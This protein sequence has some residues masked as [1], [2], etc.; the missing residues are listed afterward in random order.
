MYTRVI[1]LHVL[2]VLGF[3]LSHGSASAVMFRLRTEREPARVGALLDLCGA[4]N[5]LTS[6]TTVLLLVA[7]VLGGFMGQWW[8]RGWI[9]TALALF[10]VI[11][12]VMSFLGRIYFERVRRALAPAAND[13]P[14]ATPAEPLAA[15]L[16]S[17]RPVLVTGVG[18]G[19]LAL[20]TWLMMF[21]P[22]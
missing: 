10:V 7:G 2:S 11:G 22:F 19:G 16:D 9:W 4:V 3:L 14:P 21:K 20:I 12:V 6:V 17:G 1:F 8:G 18:L 5:G 13:G 15:A